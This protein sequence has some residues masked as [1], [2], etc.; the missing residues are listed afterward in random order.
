MFG[1]MYVNISVITHFVKTFLLTFISEVVHV[2]VA[3][4]FSVQRA[5]FRVDI[6][7]RQTHHMGSQDNFISEKARTLCRI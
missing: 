3:R 2:C 1:F 6:S 4:F 5:R 7:L